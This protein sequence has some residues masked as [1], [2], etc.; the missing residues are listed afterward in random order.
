MTKPIS[1]LFPPTSLPHHIQPT[2]FTDLYNLSSY[3]QSKWRRNRIFI[4]M[5]T[6]CSQ[7]AKKELLFKIFTAPSTLL[8]WILVCSF[9]R[10]FVFLPFRAGWDMAC[11]PV[12]CT[13][14]KTCV[15]YTLR[16]SFFQPH[17]PPPRFGNPLPPPH[18]PSRPLRRMHAGRKWDTWLVA[19]N[20]WWHWK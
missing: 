15:T 11:A 1:V 14:M 20:W 16:S 6:C 9:V 3:L 19:T 13:Y 4:S 10:S 7:T 18:T 2:C 5:V 8:S 12:S 17:I